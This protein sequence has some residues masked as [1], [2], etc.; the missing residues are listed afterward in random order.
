VGARALRAAVAILAAGLTTWG[1]GTA[2]AQPNP[3]AAMNALRATPPVAA[4]DVTFQGLDGR[5]ARLESF[6]GRPVL[7]TFFTTW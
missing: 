6:R 7:L 5:H 1:F 2:H 3:F 4:P